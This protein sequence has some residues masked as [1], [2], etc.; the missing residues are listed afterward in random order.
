[1]SDMKYGADIDLTAENDSHTKAINLVGRDKTVLDLGCY[2]GAVAEVLRTRGCTVT[3]IEIDEQA[4]E[5]AREHCDQVIVADLDEIDL[6]RA[7]AG[8]TFDVVLAG[9]VIEHLK[10]PR[11]LLAE[12]RGLLAE[13]GYV[14]VSV[15]NVAHASI[16]LELLKGQ[17]DYG[18]TGILDSTHLRFYTR[19]SIADLLES[20]GYMVEVLDWVEQKITQEAL[21]EALDPLGL[22]NLAE[23]AAAFS[24]WEAVAFQFV[25]KA[26]PATEEAVVQRL[27]EEK[28]Q[29]EYRLRV[30]EKEV[31]EYRRLADDYAR[32]T[33]E[34][35]K[36]AESVEDFKRQL[37]SAREQMAKSGEYQK[38]LEK[39]IGDKDAYVAELQKAVTE[40]RTTLEQCEARISEM[41]GLVE[42]L[43]AGAEQG[44]KRKRK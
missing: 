30:L 23:V 43:Q 5:L 12:A 17:F 42:E 28:V 6:G 37:D 18:D 15:P 21:H 1:M 26:V 16:R 29:A 10:D 36:L 32:L 33:E 14:V 22:T 3:G 39:A 35:R 8:R 41:A 25:I 9:D 44:K 7:L 31:A 13:G 40:S 20:C 24:Q 2:A 4:A 38:N 11:R 34:N 27:S 19:E